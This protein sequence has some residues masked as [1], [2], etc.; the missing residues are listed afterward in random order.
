MKYKFVFAIAVLGLLSFSTGCKKE[1]DKVEKKVESNE[2][3]KVELSENTKIIAE[4][5]G[6][7][8]VSVNETSVV[9]NAE[10]DLLNSIKVGDIIVA[11]VSER[12]PDGFLRTVNKIERNG[13]VYTFFT[14]QASLENAIVNGE[15]HIDRPISLNIEQPNTTNATAKTDAYSNSYSRTIPLNYVVYDVD[16]NNATTYD[17]VKTNGNLV[18]NASMFLDIRISGGR[19]Q[20]FVAN[21]TFGATNS[22][23]LT[24]GGV[25]TAAPTSINI[26]NSSLPNVTFFVG[27]LPITVKP[28]ID[29]FVDYSGSVSAYAKYNYNASASIKPQIKFESGVWSYSFTKSISARGNKPTTNLSASA[30]VSLRP[31]IPFMLYGCTCAS[32]YLQGEAYLNLAASISPYSKTLKAGLRAGAGANMFGYSPSNNAIFNYSV[33]L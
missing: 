24:I 22:L 3:G 14:T 28:K 27:S 10:S 17:Q 21:T 33:N 7:S 1:C 23:S 13:N 12:A 20:Y 19:L 26:F 11:S 4:N 30:N 25:M 8:I 6:K 18:L 16:R 2:N 15:I 32:A 5:L 29:I 31:R 9:F